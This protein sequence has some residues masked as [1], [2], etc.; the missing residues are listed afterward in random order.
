ME[1]VKEFSQRFAEGAPDVGRNYF[2]PEIIWDTSASGLPSAGVY[3]GR[4]EVSKFFRE[5]LGPWRDYEIDYRES[6]TRVTVPCVFRQAGTGRPAG[7]RSA[8]SSPRYLE[9]RRSSASVS[10]IA[11]ARFEAAGLSESYFFLLAAWAVTGSSATTVAVEQSRRVVCAAIRALGAEGVLRC[12]GQ[13]VRG[14]VALALLAAR[15][16]LGVSALVDREG[17]DPGRDGERHDVVRLHPQGGVEREGGGLPEEGGE[18]L[19]GDCAF[20]L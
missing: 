14:G 20:S 2:H 17:R 11:R 4:Q 19:D 12:P 3:H 18:V 8:T 13:D 9:F 6:I 15:D 5:W 16:P 10:S 1:I 7:S